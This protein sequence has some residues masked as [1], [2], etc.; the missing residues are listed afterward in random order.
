MAEVITRERSPAAIKKRFK[1]KK[2]LRVVLG[3]ILT[4]S[5]MNLNQFFRP[6]LDIQR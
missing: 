6:K 5:F 2:T 4:E 1:Y 3:I